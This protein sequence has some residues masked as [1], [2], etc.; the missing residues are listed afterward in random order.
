MSANLTRIDTLLGYRLTAMLLLLAMAGRAPGAAID[1]GYHALLPN[2][3]NQQIEIFVSGGENIAGADLFAQVGDGGPELE[4]VGLPPGTDGPTIESADFITNTI[5]AEAFGTQIDQDRA[6]ILQV[7]ASGVALTSG[8]PAP[9]SVPATGRIATLSIDT[10]G[11]YSGSFDLSLSGVLPQMNG[12][13]FDTK[14][15]GGGGNSVAVQI[16]NGT[17]A[18]TVSRNGDYNHNGIVDAADYTLWRNSFGQSGPGLTA[19]GDGNLVVDDNDYLVWK[20]AFGQLTGAPGAGATFL[21]KAVV[22]E[23]C[24]VTFVSAAVLLLASSRRRVH[25]QNAVS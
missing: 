16:L 23:P 11:F 22:P 21:D 2:T 8:P 24:T 14:L 10:T 15:I 6:G 9:Q 20:N 4:S 5:F 19:D 13:P 12:G 18:V 7:I 17:I 3:S 1:V 25:L